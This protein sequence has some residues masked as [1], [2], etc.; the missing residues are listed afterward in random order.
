[1]MIVILILMLAR[2]L[3][4]SIIHQ[5]LIIDATTK[6]KGKWELSLTSSLMKSAW[7]NLLFKRIKKASF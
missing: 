5:G 1:M 7:A 2:L 4:I 6:P 3:L